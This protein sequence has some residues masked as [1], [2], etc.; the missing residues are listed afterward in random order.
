MPPMRTAT[1]PNETG[2]TRSPVSWQHIWGKDLSKG[3]P[4][5]AQ[6]SVT[7]AARSSAQACGAHP[8][9]SNVINGPMDH[10]LMLLSRT[11]YFPTSMSIFIAP[12][13][14]EPDSMLPLLSPG[15]NWTVREAVPEKSTAWRAAWFNKASRKL[16]GLRENSSKYTW[17]QNSK[18]RQL[19][20]TEI[21]IHM[22]TSTHI[23][24]HRMQLK[25]LHLKRT[26]TWL[27]WYSSRICFQ[28][29]VLSH[30]QV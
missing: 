15:S 30:S 22:A 8:N 29:I 20:Y 9:I 4:A 25:I 1:Y 28:P 5:S 24:Y 2:P 16:L 21:L 23:G 13:T 6:T 27:Q 14:N 17:A 10:D 3:G 19:H 26:Q 11:Q 18:S 12:R 7:I